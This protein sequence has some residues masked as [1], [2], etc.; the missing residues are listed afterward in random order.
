MYETEEEFLKHYFE[1]TVSVWDQFHDG[2][3]GPMKRDQ[4]LHPFRSRLSEIMLRRPDP[5]WT[6][7]R[8]SS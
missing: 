2:I 7:A 8:P 5:A 3:I 1:R 6:K 4:L